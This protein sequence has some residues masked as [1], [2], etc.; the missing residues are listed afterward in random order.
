MGKYLAW[1]V[2]SNASARLADRVL[3]ASQ[4]GGINPFARVGAR[5]ASGII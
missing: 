3:P 5:L 2:L 4:M 1:F